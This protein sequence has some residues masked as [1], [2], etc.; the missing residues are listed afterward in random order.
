[1]RL[2]LATCCRATL[3][4]CRR[5][6]GCDEKLGQDAA[7]ACGSQCEWSSSGCVR[8]TLHLFSYLG[9]RPTDLLALNAI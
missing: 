2:C 5:L 6:R 1:V 4:R 3:R 7:S 8:T 9:R